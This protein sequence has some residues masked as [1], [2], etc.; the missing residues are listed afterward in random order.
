MSVLNFQRMDENYNRKTIRLRRRLIAETLRSLGDAVQR[1]SNLPYR[2]LSRQGDG[3]ESDD[4]EI[5]K[6]SVQSDMEPRQYSFGADH[7]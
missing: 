2:S 1:G 3:A 4:L 6:Q 7:V 5:R